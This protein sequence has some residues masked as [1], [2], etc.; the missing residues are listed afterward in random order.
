ML[1]PESYTGALSFRQEKDGPG[2]STD[3]NDTA[4]EEA[5]VRMRVQL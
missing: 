3:V 5:G 1:V 2:N 4:A